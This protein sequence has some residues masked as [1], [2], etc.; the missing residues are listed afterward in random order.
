MRKDRLKRLEDILI[1]G[2]LLLIPLHGYLSFLNLINGVDKGYGHSYPMQS[3]VLMG[4]YL[5]IVL[6]QDIFMLRYRRFEPA[7][8]LRWYWGSACVALIVV[9]L[10]YVFDFHIDLI[11]ALGLFYAPF[12]VL[13]PLLE[14]PGAAANG[15]ATLISLS[16]AEV[17]CLVNWAVC[18]S[19]VRERRKEDT[20]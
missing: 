11:S 6:A 10:L 1:L 2:V 3:Y 12:M 5:L 7:K 13:V 19:L 15:S 9:S 16:V 14:L 20:P 17:F 8:E 4:I 18:R